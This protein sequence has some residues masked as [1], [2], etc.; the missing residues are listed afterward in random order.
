MQKGFASL[1]VIIAVL[2]IALLATVTVP[3]A[4]R[5]VDRAALGYEQKRLYSELQFLRTLDRSA[6]VESTGMN[7]KYFFTGKKTVSSVAELN[8]NFDEDSY[9]ILRGGQPVR[10]PHYLS[11]GVTF[12]D[13]KDTPGYISFDANG[14]CSVKSKT[15]VLQSRRGRKATIVFDS[16]GRIRGDK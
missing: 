13:D 5:I 9:Q 8:F 7:D 12:A 6:T 10:E 3:D 11:Y 14:D 16:V 4:I 2:I 15:I 1:E